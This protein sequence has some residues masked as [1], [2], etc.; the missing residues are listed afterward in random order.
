MVVYSAVGE[1]I[2]F[3]P[4]PLK[5]KGVLSSPYWA[6]RQMACTPTFVNAVT[7]EHK[8]HLLLT[9]KVLIVSSVQ[10]C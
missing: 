6:G 8:K 2:V 3:N 10:C 5:A 7:R 4:Q 1:K 9:M